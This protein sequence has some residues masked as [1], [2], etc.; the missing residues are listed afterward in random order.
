LQ[1][2]QGNNAP[3]QVDI[4]KVEKVELD[5]MWSFVK[6]KQNQRWLWHAIDHHSHTVLAYHFGPRKDSAFKALKEK[7]SQFDIDFYYTDDWGAYERHLPKQKHLMGK[8]NTQAIERKHLTFRTR[9]KRLARKTICF[10]KLELIHDAVI[11][12]FINLFEFGEL[13]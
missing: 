5:E 4:V 12:L 8:R 11:G 13:I 3:I 1:E 9:I 2:K 10:S 7:L 6:N